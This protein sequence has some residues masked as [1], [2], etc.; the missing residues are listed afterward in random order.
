[1]LHCK[2]DM[3]T[4][5]AHKDNHPPPPP[6]RNKANAAPMPV[7]RVGSAAIVDIM[8]RAICRAVALI[9]DLIELC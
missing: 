2:K 9:V 8:S 6:Q 4:R 7:S 1:M 5:Y 3:H